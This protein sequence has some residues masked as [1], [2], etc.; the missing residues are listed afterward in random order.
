M[1]FAIRGDV[2][3]IFERNPTARGVVKTLFCYRGLHAVL[4]Y[5]TSHWFWQHGAF[6]VGRLISDVGMFL[7]DIEIHL[8]AKIGRRFFM[9]RYGCCYQ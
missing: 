2:D 1:F 8:G 7:T 5:R 3:A 4:F 6:F 9:S